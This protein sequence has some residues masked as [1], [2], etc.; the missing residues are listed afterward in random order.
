MKYLLD[1]IKK[2]IKLHSLEEDPNECCGL[3]LEIDKDLRIMKCK[4]ISKDK[5]NNFEIGP[6]D[7]LRGEKRGKIKA[8]YHSHPNDE[9]GTFSDIDKKVSLGHGIPL[10]MY[11]IKN[12]K[13]FEYIS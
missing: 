11:S 10:I 3:I 8:Y 2:E 6:H 9:I 4:N 12:N 1:H 5:L 13:F 7:Y